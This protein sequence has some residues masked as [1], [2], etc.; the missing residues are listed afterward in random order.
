MSY[1]PR[2]Y[3]LLPADRCVEAVALY[4]LAREDAMRAKREIWM[5][6]YGAVGAITGGA[7]KGRGLVFDGFAA[8]KAQGD[9]GGLCKAERLRG[10]VVAHLPTPRLAS[11]VGAFVEDSVYW[12][13][14]P[15]R[16]TKR[17]KEIASDLDFVEELCDIWQWALEKALGVYGTVY[18]DHGFHKT[19]ARALPDGRVLVNAAEDKNRPRSENCYRGFDA[20]TIPEWAQPISQEEF[21][22]LLAG[23][24]G[25]SATGESDEH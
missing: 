11:T 12:L 9:L 3:Y 22:R 7:E 2:N 10:E 6:K 25:H 24:G 13:G 19:V 17:G 21:E 5:D 14:K 16:N 15:A 4:N 18:Y 8:Y 23:R 20:S 1:C